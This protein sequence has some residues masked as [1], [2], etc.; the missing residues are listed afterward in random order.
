MDALVPLNYLFHLRLHPQRHVR[1]LMG[2]L[3]E[4]EPVIKD[5]REIEPVIEELISSLRCPAAS[6]PSN[7]SKNYPP[8]LDVMYGGGDKVVTFAL[9]D[10]TEAS[11]ADGCTSSRY[12]RKT[13]N[14]YP[15]DIFRAMEKT[16]RR[17]FESQWTW[18][19]EEVDYDLEWQRLQ[20]L[21]GVSPSLDSSL[22]EYS[23]LESSV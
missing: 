20:D 8:L 23:D 9:E 12:I 15:L 14:G 21:R 6:G 16:A 13:V 7:D 4:I 17:G 3:R 5:L 2:D 11:E 18:D 22:S 1:S 19:P 10:W